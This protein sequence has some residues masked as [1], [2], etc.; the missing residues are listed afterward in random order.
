MAREGLEFTEDWFSPGIPTWDAL[1]AAE[2][3]A[4]ILEVGCY[5]GRATCYLIATCGAR[6]PTELHCIDSWTGGVE[7]DRSAMPEV[8][9]RFDRNVAIATRAAVHP[10]SVTKDKGTSSLALPRLIASGRSG[11]F[12]MVYVDGSHQ[13]TDVLSDAVDCFRLLRVGGVMIFDDYLWSVEPAGREDP[14]NTPKLAIDAF[15]N[16]FQRKMRVRRD[17]PL[18][19]LYCEKTAA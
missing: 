19:Q 7:H 5:E 18:Y 1:I 17:L 3:P 6:R 15:L 9:A 10:V 12:D 8:E 13:A 14:L 2:Q 4:R 16:V 11:Q